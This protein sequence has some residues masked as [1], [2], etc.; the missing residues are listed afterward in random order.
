MY[1]IL[2]AFEKV[3]G[4][5]DKLGFFGHFYTMAFVMI[6]WIIFRAET[7][8]LAMHYFEMLFRFNSASDQSFL[9]YF[10]EFKAFILLGTAVS[11]NIPQK[12]FQLLKLKDGKLRETLIQISYAILFL[13]C[14]TYIVKGSYN[15][16]IYFNF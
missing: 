4:Y 15:P 10:S 11:L 3:T 5:A 7:L 14:I 1:C 8:T 12:A 13:I 16:F 6:G 2:L 9:I